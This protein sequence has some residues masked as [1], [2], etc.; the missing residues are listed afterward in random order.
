MI[1]GINTLKIHMISDKNTFIKGLIIF[2]LL[3]KKVIFGKQ[4]IIFL[5]T[6][7]YQYYYHDRYFT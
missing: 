6:I 5:S 7:N 4:Y 2:K 3:F 1:I